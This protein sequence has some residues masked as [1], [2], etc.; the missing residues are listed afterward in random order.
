MND[1]TDKALQSIKKLGITHIWYTGIIE[2]A[3]CE[4][5]PNHKIKNQHPSVVKGR[6]GSPY[7]ITDYYDVNPYLAQNIDDRMVEFEQLIGRTQ[8]NGLKAIIDFVPNHVA[9]QYGSDVFPDKDF[10]IS[11]DKTKAFLP[12]NDFYYIPDKSLVLAD[13]MGS[14]IDG[15]QVG[16][17][18]EFPARATG[19]DRFDAT[20]TIDDWY[21]TVKLNYGVD[22]CGGGKKHFA[23]VP[24][25]WDKMVAILQFWCSKNVD[26]FR[27]DMV[28]MVPVE[29]WAYAI[30]K[31]KDDYPN[32]IF[33]AEVY[34]P[35]KYNS[36]L[37]QGGFDYLYD[38][39]GLYDCLRDII[40]CDRPAHDITMCWKNLG[41]IDSKM[42]RFIEN[43]DEQRIASGFFAGNA[44]YALPA[45]FVS[46]TLNTGPVMVYFGQEV[47][48][49][50]T[51]K[52]GYSGNDGRTTIFDFYNVPEHQKWMNGGK[53]DG[54]RL[55]VGQKKLRNAYA[56]ILNF[57][58]SSKAVS[59]GK[60]YDLM[61]ANHFDGGPDTR[62]VYAYLRY[63]NDERLLVVVNFNK[64]EGQR[65][66]LK[67]PEHAFNE[68]GFL[69]DSVIKLK[70]VF[71][72][73]FIEDTTL[74]EAVD[75]GIEFN[76]GPLMFCACL[77][78]ERGEVGS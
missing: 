28:E 73:V 70:D 48:E 1:F 25:L 50:A 19:N 31:I 13:G 63:F 77:L 14:L 61:W 65:F 67:I 26:G 58:I 44:N 75:N 60:F 9:R 17:Y 76:M 52:T 53:F 16:E 49:P 5:Y 54:G 2:H 34:N 56:K 7:A 68:M 59:N 36:Y 40:C 41:G 74:F 12:S 35:D 43:H 47:G 27:C 57:S 24:P 37:G 33:I 78:V 3:T 71:S 8:K 20:P 10:G 38:K 18:V 64:T 23:P 39:V 6:A 29:F 69:H 42:L 46:A 45:M 21:E 66:K 55:S 22:Y 32:T 4:S 51:G 62:Y 72:E 15:E 30:K 11:D